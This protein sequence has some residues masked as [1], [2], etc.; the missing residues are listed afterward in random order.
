MNGGIWFSQMRT[1]S[2]F[3]M[4]DTWREPGA[5]SQE[6]HW[7]WSVLWWR[8]RKDCAQWTYGASRFIEKKVTGLRNRDVLHP[9]IFWLHLQSWSRKINHSVFVNL[10]AGICRQRLCLVCDLV[11]YSLM[12]VL[13]LTKDACDIYIYIYI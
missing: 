3:T 4:I 11:A 2:V 5:Q 12:L 13:T 10:T 7:K 1:H 6:W 8:M 9:C